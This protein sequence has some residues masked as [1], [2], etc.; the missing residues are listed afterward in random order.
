MVVGLTYEVVYNQLIL[1]GV[2]NQ[3]SGKNMFRR[4]VPPTFTEFVRLNAFLFPS[5]VIP[6]LSFVA[7]RRKRFWGLMLVGATI[8]YFSV[9]Y[10]QSWT[11]LH[12]FTP[13]MILPLVVF[14]RIYLRGSAVTRK[15]LLPAVA[16]ATALCVFFSLPRHFQINQATREFGQKTDYRIGNYES[17]YETAARGSKSLSALLPQDYR[18]K[19][20]EQPWG[21]DSYCWITMRRDQRVTR[22]RSITS[23]NPRLSLR[24]A[25]QLTS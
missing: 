10:L 19:Y 25:L 9:L 17:D 7:V 5:G 1:G 8:I 3:F 11:A 24:L 12:Q 6:I 15:W 2:N 16:T 4:L 21:T 14:W 22:Q 23:S 20:P 13:V 18:M